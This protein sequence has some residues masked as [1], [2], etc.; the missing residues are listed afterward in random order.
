[1]TTGTAEPLD[2]RLARSRPF[3]VLEPRGQLSDRVRESP[4][5][6]RLASEPRPFPEDLEACG[7]VLERAETRLQPVKPGTPC[8]RP[9][10]LEHGAGRPSPALK[11]GDPIDLD[12][13][14]TSDEGRESD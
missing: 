12:D 10:A 2:R 11:H 8:D 1:M 9:R 5:R 3:L 7:D 14:L 4:G 6:Q 13:Q